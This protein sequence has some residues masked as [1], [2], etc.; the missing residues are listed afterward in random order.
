[1]SNIIHFRVKKGKTHVSKTTAEYKHS[2]VVSGT[3]PSGCT[4]RAPTNP[5]EDKVDQSTSKK[6]GVRDAFSKTVIN[7]KQSTTVSGTTPSGCTQRAPTGLR[8]PV[9][10]STDREIDIIKPKADCQQST[11]ALGTTP[12]GCTQ[13]APANTEFIRHTQWVTNINPGKEKF[14]VAYP[15]EQAAVD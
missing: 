11:L 5:V 1:M 10:Q 13:R 15:T 7:C 4:Q 14:L 8:N 3:T 6:K 12:S 2:T 9:D